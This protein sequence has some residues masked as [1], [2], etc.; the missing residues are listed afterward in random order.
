MADS[1]DATLQPIKVDYLQ[2]TLFG[3]NALASDCMGQLVRTAPDVQLRLAPPWPAQLLKA[4]RVTFEWDGQV[5]RG[6]VQ[7]VETLTNGDLLLDI[8]PQP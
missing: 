1:T 5:C 6:V 7:Q 4:H 2:D 8:E 3:V